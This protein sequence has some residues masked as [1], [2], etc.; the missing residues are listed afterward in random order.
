MKKGIY[1]IVSSLLVFFLLSSCSQKDTSLK[2]IGII[3]IVE[4]IELDKG[5]EALIS[6]L[7]DSGFVD[8]KN[9]KINYQNAQGEISNIPMIIN[10]FKTN[11]VDLIIT[12]TT[13]C[14]IAAAQLIK[15][16]PIVFSIAF[17]P[18]QMGSKDYGK[19]ICGSYDPYNI[20]DFG[21]LIKEVL[22]N[23]FRVGLPYNSTEV[24]AN[25]SR[26]KIKKDLSAAGFEVVD[27]NVNTSNDL[28]QVAQA[29]IQK[30]IDMFMVGAD[31]VVTL[32]LPSLVKIANENKKPIFTTEA[33]N[34]EKGAAIGF[35]TDY[36]LWGQESG[37]IAVKILKGE[38]A[39]STE[40]VGKRLYI[41]LSAAQAQGLII[42][43]N[44]INR[45]D[46]VIK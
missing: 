21:S 36:K 2:T 16:I 44:L 46:K 23:K 31:N 13:P 11:K 20:E 24:N 40:I 7:K 1:L 22:P 28:L 30:N 14:T 34:I 37:K 15:D 5:R 19:N 12:I 35:G 4:D 38:E 45:A 10:Q 32:A 26:N 6:L 41:N 25:Y 29:L 43:D 27:M 18:E 39:Q 33:S 8:G 42:S 3:Q 9:I 17:S